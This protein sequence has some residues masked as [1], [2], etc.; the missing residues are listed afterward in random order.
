MPHLLPELCRAAGSG[1]PVS[2]ETAVGI[3]KLPAD[4]L[5]DLFAAASAMKRRFFGSQP[6]LCAILNA[7]SGACSEDCAFCAQSVHHATDVPVFDLHEPAAI[8]AA[9]DQA[10]ALPVSHFGVVTSGAGLDRKGVERLCRTVAGHGRQ[11]PFWC[12]SLGNLD[13]QELRAL[14]QAGLRRFHHNLETAASFFPRICT[15]HTHADRLRTLRAA[16]RAGLETCSGGILGMG[17]SLRERVA[18][19][20]ELRQERV[21]SIPLNFLIPIPGT[22]LADLTPMRPLDILRCVAMFRMTN[23]DAEIK[24]CAG[25]LH[26]RD[27][28]SMIFHA[29]ATGMMIGDLL[30]VAGRD[31]QT[32]LQMLR[33]LEMLPLPDSPRTSSSSSSSFSFSCSRSNGAPCAFE[34]ENDRRGRESRVADGGAAVPPASNRRF[35]AAGGSAASRT[36]AIGKAGPRCVTAAPRAR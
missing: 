19:A 24:V 15:T 23:P 36:A 26:L 28:Q 13:E 3:L 29:G 32:D 9:Y 5:P 16:K 6:R 21:D 35:S 30:T 2:E 25:R 1:E 4:A 10:C 22:P 34:N 8:A 33:D 14:R 31:V 20:R 12:A 17:E 18:F 11:G 27:L 7:R